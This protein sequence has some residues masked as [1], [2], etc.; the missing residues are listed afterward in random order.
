MRHYLQWQSGTSQEGKLTTALIPRSRSIK[1][2]LLDS[3]VDIKNHGF[4]LVRF[5]EE[6]ESMSLLNL[7]QWKN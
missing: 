7:A 3:E 2:D 4:F 6:R 1:D 5:L